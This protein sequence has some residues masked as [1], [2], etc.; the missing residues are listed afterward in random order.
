MKESITSK[1][2]YYFWSKAGNIAH[3]ERTLEWPFLFYRYIPSNYLTWNTELKLA[4]PKNITIIAYTRKVLIFPGR[5]KLYC[6]LKKAAFEEF[7]GC[8]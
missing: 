1:N 5:K 3:F 4:H 7:L 6:Q 8:F 2:F